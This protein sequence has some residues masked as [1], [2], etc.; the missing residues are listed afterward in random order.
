MPSRHADYMQIAEGRVSDDAWLPHFAC[1]A[2]GDV[3]V[4]VMTRNVD[5]ELLVLCGH[6]HSPGEAQ[7]LPNL[8]VLTGA[9]EYVTA[10]LTG[11]SLSGATLRGANTQA[12]TWSASAGG[13]AAAS[14][15]PRD[16]SIS[17][18]RTSVTLEQFRWALVTI[19]DN[20]HILIII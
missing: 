19:E 17:R 16:T 13:G 5:R 3:L 18:S 15:S 12:V 2:I 20:I 9:A 6:T 10:N 8:K 11:A 1:K 4:E 7:I 14:T